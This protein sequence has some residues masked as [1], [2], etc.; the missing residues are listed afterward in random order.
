MNHAKAALGILLKR[1][2]T[3][4][5]NKSLVAYHIIAGPDSD[6]LGQGQLEGL[7]AV[8]DLGIHPPGV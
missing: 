6:A 8:A 2:L 4:E 3:G 5:N 1:A 7:L